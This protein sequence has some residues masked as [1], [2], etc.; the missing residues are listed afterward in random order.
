MYASLVLIDT[1]DH[2]R[3]ASANVVDAFVGQLLHAGR[4]DDD[5][6]PIR[7][8]VLELLPLR[9]GVLSVELNVLVGGIKIFSNVHLYALVG[10]DNDTGCAIEL[11]ELGEDQA[12]GSST[13]EKDLYAD[14]RCELVETVNGTSRGLKQ[15][16][17]FVGKIFDLVEFMLR[18]RR[19][20]EQ[21]SI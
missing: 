2:Q 9:F 13:Q 21:M 1:I 19:S 14:R 18:A 3:T 4:F 8:V 17:L 5:I 20:L 10:S 12:S 6:K 15:S 11:Q 7:V 16:R